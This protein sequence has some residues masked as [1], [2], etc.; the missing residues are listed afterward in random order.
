M[1]DKA[2][3]L[4]SNLNS[5]VACT[6]YAI[7]LDREREKMP[8]RKHYYR[9]CYCCDCSQFTVITTTDYSQYTH[10]AHTNKIPKIT[11]YVM[12]LQSCYYYSKPLKQNVRFSIKNMRGAWGETYKDKNIDAIAGTLTQI[13]HM[14]TFF[15]GFSV[16]ML[17]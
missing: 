9:Y 6:R 16:S 12:C 10:S 5:R 11:C 2:I 14:W 4:K 13:F 3:R 8:E 7:S 1:N 15:C 17:Q